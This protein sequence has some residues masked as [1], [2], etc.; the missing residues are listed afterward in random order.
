[1]K[2]LIYV[3][4]V[5]MAGCAE[6]G[7][8]TITY[9]GEEIPLDRTYADF[10][11]YKND[12]NNLPVAKIPRIAE[13]VRSA[14]VARSYPSHEA[15][16]QALFDLMFPGYGFSAMNLGTPVALFAVEI[17]RMNEQRYFS[18]VQDGESWV[19]REDFVWPDAKGFINAAVL[20]DGQIRYLTHSDE[21]VRESVR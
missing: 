15:A 16:F 19:L 14:P 5:L 11:E 12:E 20:T 8:D 4:F 1:M 18:F 13:L 3:A 7:M 17:P 21:V 2:T 6:S 10:N 9:R